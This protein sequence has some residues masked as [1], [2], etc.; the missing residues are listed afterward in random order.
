MDLTIVILF[1]VYAICYWV[2][3]FRD[4]W[5]PFSYNKRKMVETIKEHD[6]LH[7]EIAELEEE[8]ELAIMQWVDTFFIEEIKKELDSKN[9]RLKSLTTY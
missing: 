5:D 7:K 9:N 2:M 3:F 8:L 6:Y 1:A 4:W